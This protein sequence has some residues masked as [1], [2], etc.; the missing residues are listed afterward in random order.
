MS[1]PSV[2]DGNACWRRRWGEGRVATSPS[3]ARNSI[4]I[5]SS[6]SLTSTAS[7]TLMSARCTKEEHT[8]HDLAK[9]DALNLVLSSRPTGRV[10]RWNPPTISTLAE[11][12]RRKEEKWINKFRE[13]K[14]ESSRQSRSDERGTEEKRRSARA[15][16]SRSAN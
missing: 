10:S 13:A 15:S 16:S 3:L 2:I 11:I 7:P 8:F 9:K 4:R 5:R 1:C 6:A 14:I 12:I